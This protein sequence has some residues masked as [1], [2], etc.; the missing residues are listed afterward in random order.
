MGPAA[1]E[2]TTCGNCVA[3][4]ARHATNEET[5]LREEVPVQ[6]HL[7]GSPVSSASSDLTRPWLPSL[8]H[9]TTSTTLTAYQEGEERG[10]LQTGLAPGFACARSSGPRR[11]LRIQNAR[12]ST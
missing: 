11:A 1:T 4:N 12:P 9:L 5:G 8:Q 3:A 10:S 6:A 2:A 7:A